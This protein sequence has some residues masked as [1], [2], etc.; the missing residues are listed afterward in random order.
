MR[1]ALHI[2]VAGRSTGVAILAEPENI[3]RLKAVLT[4]IRFADLPL[5]DSYKTFLT[6][7]FFDHESVTLVDIEDFE[8][9]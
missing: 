4:Q 2:I 5:E 1:K 9:K 8:I 6:D 7:A 3:D